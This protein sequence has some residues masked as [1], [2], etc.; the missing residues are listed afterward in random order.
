MIQTTVV[1]EAPTALRLLPRD[2]WEDFLAGFTKRFRHRLVTIEGEGQ[3]PRSCE[4]ERVSLDQRDGDVLMASVVL[5]CSPETLLHSRITEP[6][7][8]VALQASNGAINGL[9]ITPMHGSPT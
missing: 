5:R 1:I 2:D 4:L 8:I 7:R 6:R 3:V 9:E